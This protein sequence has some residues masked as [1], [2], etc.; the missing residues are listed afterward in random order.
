VG[1]CLEV[2]T[3][4]AVWTT[5]ASTPVGAR[6]CP[7]LHSQTECRVRGGELPHTVGPSGVHYTLALEGWR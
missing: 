4:R 7:P 5:D 2:L 3:A 6:R 1:R